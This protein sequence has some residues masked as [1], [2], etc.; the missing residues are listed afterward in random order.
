MD[1]IY[2]VKCS[3]S[4]RF[5]IKFKNLYDSL[6]TKVVV[7]YGCCKYYSQQLDIYR[8]TPYSNFSIIC[9]FYYCGLSY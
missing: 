5:I 4:N 3:T 6:E 7:V 1:L 2:F 9:A 8:L